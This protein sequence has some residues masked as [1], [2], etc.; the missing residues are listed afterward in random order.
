ML[1]H[2]NFCRHPMFD[3]TIQGK[4]T[5]ILR[6]RN[7]NLQIPST[8]LERQSKYCGRHYHFLSI[9]SH[10]LIPPALIVIMAMIKSLG[11]GSQFVVFLLNSSVSRTTVVTKK[12]EKNEEI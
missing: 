5:M 8:S 2:F 10:F 9:T 4:I 6:E 7:L 3:C 11:V 1:L 12:R